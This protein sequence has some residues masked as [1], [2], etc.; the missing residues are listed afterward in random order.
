MSSVVFDSVS[1]P[2]RVGVDPPTLAYLKALAGDTEPRPLLPTDGDLDDLA[3]I[4]EDGPL[5]FDRRRLPF[6]S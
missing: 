5:E 3:M 4:F 1:C 2:L 6:E